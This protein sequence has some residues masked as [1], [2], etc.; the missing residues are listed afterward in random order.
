[1]L[2]S[3]CMVA[4]L[5]GLALGAPNTVSIKIIANDFSDRLLRGVIKRAIYFAK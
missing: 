2:S 1:M 5:G 4:W 3:P